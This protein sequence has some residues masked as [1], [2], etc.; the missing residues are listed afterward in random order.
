MIA[1]TSQ[2][3]SRTLINNVLR[4]K[5]QHEKQFGRLVDEEDEEEADAELVD[6]YIPPTIGRGSLTKPLL[7]EQ[8]PV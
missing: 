1:F 5:Q 3:S 4:G 7:S 6:L 2:Y 8:N